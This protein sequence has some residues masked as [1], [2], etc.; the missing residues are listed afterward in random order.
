MRLRNIHNES[1]VAV[2]NEGNVKMQG[3]D[4][5]TNVYIK[6]GTLDMQV[7]HV[8]NES[9][10]HI[11]EG[12]VDLKMADNHPVKLCVTG[13]E[14]TVDETSAKYGEK[15]TKEDEFQHYFGTVQPDKFS[16]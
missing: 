15:E 5:S 10:V 13:K 9:R 8:S 11:E 16:P 3:V 7:S 6:K 4:G 12:D 14:L 2:Y 1:Y